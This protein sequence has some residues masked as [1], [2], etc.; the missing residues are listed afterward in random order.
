MSPPYFRRALK[1][2]QHSPSG[3]TTKSGITSHLH[4]F[5]PLL[6]RLWNK[7]P[8]S[9][10]SH[11]SLQ[12]FKTVCC[13][14]CGVWC[15]KNNPASRRVKFVLEDGVR[16]DLCDSSQQS[17]TDSGLGDPEAQQLATRSTSSG[18]S[19]ALKGPGSQLTAPLLSDS[20]YER[21]TP[22]GCTGESEHPESGEIRF[23]TL[24]VSVMHTRNPQMFHV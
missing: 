10:Q 9:V 2:R 24:S 12:A 13:Y 18:M 1:V 14:G 8:H 20:R 19:A 5:I 22:D 21:T 4:S 23:N 7:L 15:V 3:K 17:F 6:P 11:S 16:N